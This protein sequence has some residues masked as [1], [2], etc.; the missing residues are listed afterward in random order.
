[1]ARRVSMLGL[2]AA[3]LCTAA[4][5]RNCG[6][7]GGGF[8][9]RARSEPTARLVGRGNCDTCYD[10]G[11]G[12]PIGSP[13][14]GSPGMLIP[15]SSGVPGSRADELPYPQPNMIP[16]A[17]VPFAPPGVAPAPGGSFGEVPGTKSGVPVKGNK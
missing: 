16:P 8:T 4:G 13:L 14:P 1:M 12:M 11:T 9:S 15:G 10:A 5:C 6:N 3:L 2:A 7:S 17:G